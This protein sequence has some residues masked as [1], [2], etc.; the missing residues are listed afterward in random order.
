M[1]NRIII[2]FLLINFICIESL[3]QLSKDS[4]QALFP[5]GNFVS[6]ND[7]VACYRL[8][9][10]KKGGMY[11]FC[12]YNQDYKSELSSP[13]HSW[14]SQGGEVTKW[15]NSPCY[16]II[17]PMYDYALPFSQGWAPVCIGKKWTYVSKD[18]HYLFDRVSS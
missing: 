14:S 9:G 18:G 11:G 5:C 4:I 13:M 16:T 6:F 3:A 2:I 8:K 17:A 15:L 12:Y 1:K 7:N 10:I